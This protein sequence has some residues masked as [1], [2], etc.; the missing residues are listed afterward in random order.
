MELGGAVI[1]FTQENKEF[2]ALFLQRII[3]IIDWKSPLGSE[4]E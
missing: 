1:E 2:S 3:D 4:R